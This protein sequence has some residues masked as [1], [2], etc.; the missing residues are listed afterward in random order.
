MLI[1]QLSNSIIEPRVQKALEAKADRT[2]SFAEVF[3]PS[4]ICNQMNNYADESWFGRKNVFNIENEESWS[5]NGDR[6]TFSEENPWTKY[7]ILTMQD[8]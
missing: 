7:V 8:D 4:W 3:T 6:I 1:E 2:K 5:P